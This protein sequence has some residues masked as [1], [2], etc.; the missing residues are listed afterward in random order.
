MIFAELK[1]IINFECISVLACCF[2]N[3]ELQVTYLNGEYYAVFALN[4]DRREF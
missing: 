2:N 1:V 3:S 4:S